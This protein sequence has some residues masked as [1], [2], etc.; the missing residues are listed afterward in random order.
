[1]SSPPSS[2]S[3]SSSSSSSS[4][5]CCCLATAFDPCFLPMLVGAAED[6]AGAAV[7]CA[8]EGLVLACA[9]FPSGV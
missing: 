4:W 8:D 1:M 2:M 9:S 3:M 5:R 7:D 6:A